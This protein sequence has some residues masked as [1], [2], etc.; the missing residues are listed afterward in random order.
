MRPM[1]WRHVQPGNLW[2]EQIFGGGLFWAIKKFVPVHNLQHTLGIGAVT[3]KHPI[4]L[5]AR[6]NGPVQRDRHRAT[7]ARLLSHQTKI[8]DENRFYWIGKIVYLGH[9]VGPPLRMP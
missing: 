6:R 3:K 5:G 2:G 1:H 4:A 8:S 7:C 9:A